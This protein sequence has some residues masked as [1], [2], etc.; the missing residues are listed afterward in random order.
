MSKNRLLQQQKMRQKSTVTQPN[1]YE[2]LYGLRDNPF[3]NEALFKTGGNDPRQNGEIYD[4]EFRQGEERQFFERFVQPPTGDKP[5]SIGFLRLEQQARGRGNGK[6]AFLHHVMWRVNEQ[7][8]EEWPRDPDAPELFA[9]AV[10][11]LPEPTKQ[12]NFF[13]LVRLIFETMAARTRRKNGANL[14]TLFE[15]VDAD[16]RAAVLYKLLES[17]PDRIEDLA[18][19]PASDM[20]A[21]LANL[22]AFKSLLQDNGLTWE[23]FAEAAKSA[24]VAES[25]GHFNEEFIEDLE[26]S[27]W[28]LQEL[29]EGRR[30]GDGY[31]GLSDHY[32]QR[33][34]T[35]WLIDGLMPVLMAAGYQRFHLLLDEFEKI[36]FY[37]TSKKRDEFL[38]SFRQYFYERPS[39]VMQRSF[40]SSLL[41][42]HP[43][44]DKYLAANW[45]R[46]G[47]ED[48]APLTPPRMHQHSIL[49]G[50]SQIP[51]LDHVIVTYLDWYR[52]EDHAKTHA[53]T[54]YPFSDDALHPAMRAAQLF[55]RSTLWYAHAILRNAAHDKQPAPITREYVERFVSKTPEPPV[56]DEDRWFAPSQTGTNLRG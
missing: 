40:I 56:D 3:P 19:I 29:W 35:D 42:I 32:W 5:L 12:K 43:S 31:A 26:L 30:D 54:L 50:A 55:P 2:V 45:A 4:E 25:G 10:H 44:V 9:L 48:I 34:G 52:T 51:K 41:T 46:A 7:E 22:T 16:L 24:V 36:Y 21:S 13:Q 1:P 49:L 27:S 28:E 37:Q 15:K 8:W 6:S 39:A 53:G 14:S 33:G 17:E 18:K 38:D 20:N 11:V 23:Q 47:L